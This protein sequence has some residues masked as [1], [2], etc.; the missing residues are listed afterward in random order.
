[1][2]MKKIH[3]IIT[4]F[5]FFLFIFLIATR[6]NEIQLENNRIAFDESNIIN[7]SVNVNIISS[8]KLP[9]GKI[10]FEYQIFTNYGLL[11]IRSNKSKFNSLLNDET[12][13]DKLTKP[14]VKS[15]KLG[16]DKFLSKIYITHIKSCN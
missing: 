12:L 1:M 6:S 3:L 14:N 4:P 8:K 11:L 10:G 15:C 13:Y 5:I 2:K 7:E 16:V 9:N